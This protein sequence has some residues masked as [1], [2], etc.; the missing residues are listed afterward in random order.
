MSS[1]TITIWVK[2]HQHSK[3]SRK[4]NHRSGVVK[5]K[6]TPHTDTKTWINADKSIDTLFKSCTHHIASKAKIYETNIGNEK[7][8]NEVFLMSHLFSLK[9]MCCILHTAQH[10]THTYSI[11]NEK[12]YATDALWQSSVHW[13]MVLPLLLPPLRMLLR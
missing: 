2:E 6:T 8:A 5:E 9:L 3:R 1:T 7:E 10:S 13:L 12:M 4:E 11:S